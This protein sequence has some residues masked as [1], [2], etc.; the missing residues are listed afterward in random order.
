MTAM[1]ALTTTA[2]GE[3]HAAPDAIKAVWQI[4]TY[5][6]PVHPSAFPGKHVDPE[7]ERFG[8]QTRVELGNDGGTFSVVQSVAE[9]LAAR[10]AA[11]RRRMGRVFRRV[12]TV[13]AER[14]AS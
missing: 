7:P 14:S 6:P 1:V 12:R 3:L 9:V 2:G 4:S 11:Y 13:F 8:F 5:A 10:E